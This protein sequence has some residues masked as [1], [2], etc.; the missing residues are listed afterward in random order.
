MEHHKKKA[1]P[2]IHSIGSDE[3]EGFQVNSLE[4][5]F[6]KVIEEDFP[7]PKKDTLIYIQE[8]HKYQIEK[9]RKENTHNIL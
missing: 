3:G 6:N 9:T 7:K 5:I 4:Q 8:A 2:S 1:Q